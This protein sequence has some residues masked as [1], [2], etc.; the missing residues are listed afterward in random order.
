MKSF[1]FDQLMNQ[2]IEDNPGWN[3]SLISVPTALLVRYTKHVPYSVTED[4]VRDWLKGEFQEVKKQK[5]EK[6]VTP[7]TKLTVDGIFKRFKDKQI[8]LEEANELLNTKLLVIILVGENCST[9]DKTFRQ[10]RNKNKVH[11]IAKEL[12]WKDVLNKAI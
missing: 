6:M 11:Q 12:L 3:E 2:F 8:S 1:T 4:D 7:E 5:R 10:K 9:G